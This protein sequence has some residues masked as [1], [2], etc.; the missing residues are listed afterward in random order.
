MLLE[1]IGKQLMEMNRARYPID[2][3]LEDHVCEHRREHDNATECCICHNREH[4]GFEELNKAE[5]RLWIE[6]LSIA[7]KKQEAAAAKLQK[8]KDAGTVDKD[9]P[10]K[11]CKYTTADWLQGIAKS[12]P[13]AT[14]KLPARRSTTS[15]RA[16]AS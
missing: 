7:K 14:T 11:R 13:S 10:C 15:C 5:K 1:A 12:D 4:D 8:A 2:E 3:L 6:F 9:S 16:G